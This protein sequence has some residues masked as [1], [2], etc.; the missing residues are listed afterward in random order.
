MLWCQLRCSVRL[1]LQLFVR[2]LI[3]YLHYL[4]SC[5]PLKKHFWN[6]IQLNV[7]EYW[8]GNQKC[9]I[10]RNWQ[11]RVHKTQDEDKQNKNTI[12]VKSFALIILSFCVLFF[13]W[14]YMLILINYIFVYHLFVIIHGRDN[15]MITSIYKFIKSWWPLRL[16]LWVS[17]V[18]RF[19][20][21]NFRMCT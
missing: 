12:C 17:P 1:Y 18:P 8:K 20:R 11:H 5:I 19:T 15:D 14:F 3:S 6:V 16:W 21:Y 9:A 10:Q 13:S 4:C 2:S 7:R